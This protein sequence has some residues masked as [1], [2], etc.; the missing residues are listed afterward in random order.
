[1]ESIWLE[2]V[3][4]FL[5]CS[6]FPPLIVRQVVLPWNVHIL[7]AT[8]ELIDGYIN[9]PLTF[10]HFFRVSEQMN[11]EKELKDKAGKI[12]NSTFKV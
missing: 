5:F 9:C 8:L 11:N 4:P 6:Y 10:S 2:R 1:M 7:F 12:L 3:S